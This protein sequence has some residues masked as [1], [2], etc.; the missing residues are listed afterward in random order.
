MK[1]HVQMFIP[2]SDN[3][4]KKDYVTTRFKEA[5]KFNK[6][7]L[8]KRNM[9]IDFDRVPEQELIFIMKIIIHTLDSA[10]GLDMCIAKCEFC[11]TRLNMFNCMTEVIDTYLK[12][13]NPQVF[14]WIGR[15]HLLSLF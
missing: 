15:Y 6:E 2:C 1:H 9:I 11:D 14:E 5:L 4:K 13:T 8:Q 7:N 10:V 12:N 3:L